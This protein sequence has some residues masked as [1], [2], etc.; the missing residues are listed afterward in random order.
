MRRNEACER[1]REG[2][3][4]TNDEESRYEANHM[5]GAFSQAR[6][7]HTNMTEGR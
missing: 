7:G 2:R 6:E 5:D 4:G 3:T 1:R